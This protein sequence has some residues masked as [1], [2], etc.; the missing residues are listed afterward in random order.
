MEASLRQAFP[1]P[2]PPPQTSSLVRYGDEIVALRERGME[3][4]AIRGRLE[5]RHRMPVS[6]SAVWRLVHRL[7]AGAGAAA[8]GAQDVF[9][10]V[11]TP[12]G[13]EAQVDF[14]YAGR[15][16]DPA[17][18]ALRKSWVFTMVLSWSRH[19]YAALVFDQRVETWFLC[20]RHAFEF[21][22]GVPE[23]VVL[24]HL[25]AAIARRAPACQP[26]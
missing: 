13:Q 19:Q 17:S 12:A 10:R 26:A 25:K 7:E 6:Y 24:D 23:R 21:F 11:E 3:I 18:G 4:A 22:G 14:G 15:A 8:N 20:H 1:S 2:L 9:V 5:E 16:L